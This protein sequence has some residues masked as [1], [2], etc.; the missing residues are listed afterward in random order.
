MDVEFSSSLID[1]HQKQ[2]H[3]RKPLIINHAG[4]VIDVTCA[5]NN[6]D[7]KSS[8]AI[9]PNTPSQPQPQR[10]PRGT[11]YQFDDSFMG[12]DSF[13]RLAKMIGD[14]C[15][16]CSMYIQ[17][18]DIQRKNG[19]S[20]ELRCS[21][22]KVMQQDITKFDVG[23]FSKPGTKIETVK[24]KR[25]PGEESLVDRMDNKK[26]KGHGKRMKQ[27]CGEIHNEL[28]GPEISSEKKKTNRK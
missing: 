16:D 27:E 5:I 1:E 11:L 22:Y 8:P 18:R 10:F 28:I 12:K 9:T 13:D 3:Y 24:R 4:E 21:C 25:T 19:F 23:Y 26:L 2:F 15:S 6:G 7:G 14:N 17:K 20:F